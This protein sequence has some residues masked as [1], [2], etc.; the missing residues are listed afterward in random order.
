MGRWPNDEFP[1]LGI[2]RYSPARKNHGSARKTAGVR[3]T[4]ERPFTAT[5]RR[6]ACAKG[7]TRFVANQVELNLWHGLSTIR[8]SEAIK[9]AL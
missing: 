9:K 5:A 1:G 8:K 7:G 3:Y 4:L 2:D 6:Q